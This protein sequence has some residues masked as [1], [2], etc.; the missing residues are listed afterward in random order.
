M[1]IRTDVCVR[2]VFVWEE[3]GVPGGNS[4]VWLGDH[5]TISHADAGYRTRVAAVRALTDSQ[6]QLLFFPFHLL[7][8]SF[9]IP[10]KT[11]ND[12]DFE[13]FPDF[14][15]YFFCP[16]LFLEKEPVFPFSMLSAKQGNNWCHFY[17]VFGMTRSLTRDWTRDL[18]HWMSA[19][20]Y[21][22]GSL[23][24]FWIALA[25]NLKRFIITYM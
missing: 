6:F 5:M 13:V 18:P 15:L 7:F 4:P 8:F 1:L 12:S 11:A 16:I 24:Y 25:L 17:N 14:I 22:G 21:R 10:A 9:F 2:M 19:L 3:T 23:S 20:G